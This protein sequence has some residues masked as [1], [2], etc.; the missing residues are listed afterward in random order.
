M[1]VTATRDSN[2]LSC[3]PRDKTVAS[4][5]SASIMDGDILVVLFSNNVR[6]AIMFRGGI[7]VIFAA[8]MI[9][10]TAGT[11]SAQSDEIFRIYN[12][13]T[14]TGYDLGRG[15]D[16]LTSTP[17]NQCVVIQEAIAHPELG[18]ESVVFRSYRIESSQQLDKAL[19]ISASASIKLG[20][21][22]GTASSSY[23]DSLSISSYTLN[24]VVDGSVRQK[25]KSIKV[26]DLQDRY[27]RL[28]SSGNSDGYRRFRTICGDGYIAEMPVGGDFKAV[29]Q[30]TT[31]SRSEAQ[32]LSVSLGG[33]YAAVSGAAS[34]S[35]AVKKAAETNEVRIWSYRRGGDGP[36]PITPDEIA[37]RAANLPVDV[38]QAPTP[39][40]VAVYSYLGILD[41]PMLPLATFSE[42]AVQIER[43]ASLSAKARDQL[44]DVQYIISHPA[45]FFGQPSDII[46]LTNEQNALIEFRK[47][48][49]DRAD[50]CIQVDGMCVVDNFVVPTPLARPA[51]R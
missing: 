50:Q 31:N 45:Q 19:G 17:R 16:I 51:R 3:G 43:L 25:G 48:V 2:R 32:A 21:G 29:I 47:L 40:Q 9:V 42:R 26:Q 10:G 34:F 44:S 30:I 5:R 4:R 36:V 38:K 35:N 33:S 13:D 27:K 12:I 24:Y 1:G 37:T 23:S 22:S 46:Q 49:S 18:P 11:A 41:D 6:I 39:L 14:G 20:V 8:F 28:L 7:F 15:F